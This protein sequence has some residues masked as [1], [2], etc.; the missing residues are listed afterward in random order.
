MKHCNRLV[1]LCMCLMSYLSFFFFVNGGSLSI[2]L[3][4]TF[5]INTEPQGPRPGADNHYVTFEFSVT[6]T[7]LYPNELKCQR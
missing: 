4:P 2:S 5:N 7:G 3:T 1:V 6:I